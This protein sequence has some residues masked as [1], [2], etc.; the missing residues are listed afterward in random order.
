VTDDNLDFTVKDKIAGRDGTDHLKSIRLLK[1]LGD[2]ATS[3]DDVVVAL[4]NQNPANITLSSSSVQESASVGSFLGFV[5]GADPDGDSMTYSLLDSAGGR[6]A[7]E[8]GSFL[9]LKGALDY[10]AATSHQ[11]VV[12]AVD[13]YGGEFIKTLT[14][15]VTNVVE[16]TPVVRS[17][18]ATSERL[19]GENGNDWL[20]GIDGD[21]TLSG[22][23]GNDLLVGGDSNGIEASGNDRLDGGAGNDRLYGC[24]GNDALYG[25]DGNDVVVGGNGDL[26]S[27]NDF[28]S[29]G[30]GNDSLYGGDGADILY[31]NNGK[32]LLNGGSGKD[33]FMFNARLTS[34]NLDSI[35]DFK[36]VDDTIKLSRSIF[37][38]IS[39]GTLSSKAFVIGDRVKDKD[40]RIIYHKKAGALFYDPDGTG[41]AKAVQFATIQKNLILTHKDFLIF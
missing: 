3:S 13:A 18:T 34:A 11:I 39:K 38:K 2:T 19:A 4:N 40:D 20:S 36:P 29:G 15:N 23:N 25:S 16:N 28:L 17:G 37:T 12:K 30:N 26:P 6:F 1:F 41:A 9:Y 14:I 21:D 5:N 32:D 7:I 22:G 33:S 24:T 35:I 8:A 27:G 10:E 31:G